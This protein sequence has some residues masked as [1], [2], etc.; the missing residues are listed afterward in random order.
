MR[1]RSV[2]SRATG[3]AVQSRAS[4]SALS[5]GAPPALPPFREAYGV[6]GALTSGVDLLRGLAM[7]TG[8]DILTITGVTDGPDNDF[9]AQAN[10]ALKAL[11]NH[12]L[13][14]VHVEAPD[15][16]G[17]GGDA[18]GK[19]AAIEAI[20]RE[21]LGR[22]RQDPRGIRLLVM[23]DHPTP[24]RLRTPTPDPVP[25]LMTGPGRGG[26]APRFTEAN[27]A[28]TGV[29]IDPGYTIMGSFLGITA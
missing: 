10:G 2:S 7:M 12:D 5:S 3:S 16:A 21:I 22:F 27:A 9:A 28:G 25:F 4:A 23:P 8:L 29:F 20:D 6:T 17:H 15:E 19:I 1:I 18:D 13:V 14:I 24:V 26:G 11:E